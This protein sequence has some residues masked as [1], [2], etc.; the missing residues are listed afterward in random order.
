MATDVAAYLHRGYLLG[1][2]LG[3]VATATHMAAIA[4]QLTNLGCPVERATATRTLVWWDA[5]STLNALTVDGRVD[6]QRLRPM[7]RELA[8]P[9]G[10][11]HPMRVYGELSDLLAARGDLKSAIAMEQAAS[12]VLSGVSADVLCGYRST[13]FSPQTASDALHAICRAHDEVRSAPGDD[14]AAWLLTR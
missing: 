1:E 11:P 7:L 4:R 5:A 3:I 8:A 9:N 14:L 10:R 12:Q 2:H 13:H 6:P